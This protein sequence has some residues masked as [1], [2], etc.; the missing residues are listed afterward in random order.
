[1]N[2]VKT[3]NASKLKYLKIW[4]ILNSETDEEHPM[5]TNEL[6][7]KLEELGIHCDRRTLYRNI[8]ELNEGGYEILI[9][10]TKSDTVGGAVNKYYVEDRSF[11]IP[12]IL[13][14]MNAVQAASFITEKKTP[15]LLDKIAKLAG[16]QRGEVLKRNIVQFGTVKGTNESIYYSISEIAYAIINKKKIGFNYFDYEIGNQRKY[17]MR[18]SKPEEKKL[19]VVNP[20]ATDFHDDKYYLFCYDDYYG[21]VVQYRIDRMD[22]VRVLDEDISPSKEGENFSLAKHQKSMISMHGGKIE[23]VTIEAK[24]YVLDAI[25][26]K[27]GSSIKMTEKDADTII[28]SVEV[29]ISN[30]FITWVCGFG[31][32]LKIIS[33]QNVIEQIKL[34]LQEA[35]QNYQ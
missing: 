6:L 14:L 33:P 8:E 30:P 28:F 31:E 18:R 10:K 21:N 5:S 2:T 19:Y 20:M 27:L 25:Y 34:H 7:A 26:D 22:Q 35:L 16:S 11:D 29:Q 32:A 17:R 9:K 1:M 23:K 12:E 4:E 13:I 15:V 24:R 3:E